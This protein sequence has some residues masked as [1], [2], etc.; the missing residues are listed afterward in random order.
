M[1][2]RPGHRLR[3]VAALALAAAA[4]SPAHATDYYWTYGSGCGGA[5]FYGSPVPQ[6]LVFSCWNTSAIA[7]FGYALGGP[8]KAGD[9]VT[10]EQSQDGDTPV[11]FALSGSSSNPGVS[12]GTL[13]LYGWT[14]AAVATLDID[15]NT[16]NVSGPV[17]IGNVGFGRVNQ[18]G[19]TINAS[20]A[21]SL[22]VTSVYA[23]RAEGS[24]NL[25]GGSLQVAAS[26][27]IALGA[28]AGE[29]LAQGSFNLSGSG[30]VWAPALRVAGSQ[31]YSGRYTQT[32]G[33]ASFGTVVLG[34]DPDQAVFRLAGGTLSVGSVSGGMGR[35]EF[36]GGTLGPVSRIDVGQFIVGSAPN[37]D[38]SR[39]E[40]I[41]APTA[42][43]TLTTGQLIVGQTVAGLLTIRASVVSGSAALGTSIGFLTQGDGTVAIAGSG[44]SWH[45]T[46]GVTVGG[47][48]SA[49]GGS[50]LISV[51]NGANVA[52]DGRLELW[53]QG[54][55]QVNGGA[56]TVGS[57]AGAGGSTVSL[58][59]GTFTVGG[60]GGLGDFAGTLNWTRGKLEIASSSLTLG[61]GT[62]LG[63]ALTLG[64]GQQLAVAADITGPTASLSLQGGAL[65]VGGNLTLGQFTIGAG[66]SFV[67]DATRHLQLSH[68]LV[69]QGNLTNAGLVTALDGVVQ[70]GTLVFDGSGRMTVGLAAFEA[71]AGS[72]TR[73]QAGSSRIIGRAVFD[74]G[75]TLQVDAAAV[76][77]FS[78]QVLQAPGMRIL[79][80]GTTQYTYGLQLRPG[81][82]TLIEDGSAVFGPGATYTVEVGRDSAGNPSAAALAVGGNLEFGGNLV[83][84]G[85][86]GY[87]AH[88]G[89][90]FTLFSW[91]ST[92]GS[93]GDIEASGLALGPG[94]MLDASRLYTDGTLGVVAVPE[95]ATWALMLGGLAVTAVAR[96]RRTLSL[97]SLLRRAIPA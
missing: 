54:A 17:L 3:A 85:S 10:L 89:D 35:F 90:R 27:W 58:S 80:T 87:V 9:N 31:Y 67:N 76:L 78:G 72:V 79:G 29:T 92:H 7:G 12:I 62:P 4:A 19:G 42:I 24:Y 50:G 60:A 56:I 52:I 95:P 75:S 25:S 81:A 38:V 64:A 40:A 36:D 22:G 91:A 37:A 61:A 8:P 33:A 45:N 18:T 84:N 96:R 49:S 43:G 71:A 66:S 55:L 69:N 48:A 5:D 68:A 14:S 44:S 70:Q 65:T 13:T 30:S 82:G 51:G 26:S 2:L 86:N 11:H 46:G 83:L 23:P 59:G 53:S 28:G 63:N 6:Q 32:G 41:I 21:V 77:T 16:L 39:P 97:R 73:A 15:R 47:T 20:G 57:L 34:A 74:P 88:A 93:F 1:T 94:L